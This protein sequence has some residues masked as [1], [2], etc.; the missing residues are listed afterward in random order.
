MRRL[1]CAVL[2][3]LLLVGP[4]FALSDA[5]YK[6]LRKNSPDFLQ[7]D[8]ELAQVWDGLKDVLTGREFEQLRK[9]QRQWI[10]SGRDRAARKLM[11]EEGYTFEEAYTEATRERVDALKKYY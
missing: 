2:L 5:D 10:K 4:A 7:A 8:R 11:R 3:I 1:F 9:E 6:I